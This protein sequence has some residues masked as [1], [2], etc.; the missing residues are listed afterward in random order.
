MPVL[1][2]YK[3]THSTANNDLQAFI[4]LYSVCRIQVNHK[5]STQKMQDKEQ[6]LTNGEVMTKSARVASLKA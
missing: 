6:E 3:L 4:P 1:R 2:T 5:M